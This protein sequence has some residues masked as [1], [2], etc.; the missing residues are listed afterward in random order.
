MDIATCLRLKPWLG[1]Q[2]RRDLHVRLRLEEVLV[3]VEFRKTVDRWRRLAWLEQALVEV[4]RQTVVVVA[5]LGVYAELGRV[6]V[7]CSEGGLLGLL[8]KTLHQLSLLA[9]LGLLGHDALDLFV[10]PCGS[11]DVPSGRGLDRRPRLHVL[12][13]L[14]LPNVRLWL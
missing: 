9:E 13:C 8:V 14:R 1:R 4:L 7:G 12:T 3:L 6:R 10:R 5:V 11:P 2:I